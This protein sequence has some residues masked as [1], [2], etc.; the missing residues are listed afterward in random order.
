MV[1]MRRETALLLLT[2]CVLGL[3]IQAR[4]ARPTH[5]DRLTPQPIDLRVNINSADPATL[6]LLPRIGPTLARAIIAHRERAGAFHELADLLEVRGIGEAT[7]AQFAEL[8]VL[9]DPDGPALR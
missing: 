8:I 6:C 4:L 9:G 1:S 2:L 5:V 3:S 7:L